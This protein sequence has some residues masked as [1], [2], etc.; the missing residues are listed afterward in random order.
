MRIH[1]ASASG[2]VAVM[3]AASLLSKLLGMVRS[4]LFAAAFGSGTQAAAYVAATRIPTAL[5]DLLLSAV[6]SVGMIPVLGRFGEE[7]REA[8]ERFSDSFLTLSFL[9][10]G[11]FTLCGIVLAP[12]LVSWM[13]PGL[14]TEGKRLAVTLLRLCFPSLLFCTAAYTLVGILQSKGRYV[15]PSL[16]SVFSN[17]AVILYLLFS[18]P[19]SPSLRIVGL[20]GAYSLGWLIQALTLLLPLLQG[21]FRYRPRLS[22]TDDGLRQSFRLAFPA[23]VCAWMMPI[24]LLIGTARAS[25]LHVGGS[26]IYDYGSGL[27]LLLA[28]IC[29]HSL[30]S[31]LFPKLS[32]SRGNDFFKIAKSGLFACLAITL[33]LA[34]A[35]VILSERGV[36]ILYLR[37][38]FTAQDAAETAA[39]LRYAALSLPA[40]AAGEW[41]SRVCY[42]SDLL[43]APKTAALLGIA[44]TALISLTAPTLPSL[45]LGIAVGQTVFAVCLTVSVFFRIFG[46]QASDLACA[47]IKLIICTLPCAVLMLFLS[48]LPFP[49]A[50]EAGIMGN[51]LACLSVF[52]PG[53]ALFLLFF[54][55]FRLSDY[56]TL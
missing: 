21:G 41:L 4:L 54:R 3:T 49:P 35:S 8:R 48:L 26:A 24:A 47:V 39:L 7:N 11:F 33:P 44:A 12:S 42:A 40:F 17:G 46:K 30:T 20:A 19:L 51:A 31:Y 2:T 13:A 5:F 9:V 52:L 55:L 45:G 32:Q 36:C 28:G 23:T 53:M 56:F 14:D 15:L 34:I 25:V 22:L 27:F 38:A 50:S 6:L 16:I 43:R 37:G 10:G 18:A 29:S 1:W